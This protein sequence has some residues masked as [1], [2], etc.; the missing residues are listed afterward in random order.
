MALGDRQLRRIKGRTI[1]TICRYSVP[2]S[3]YFG[4]MAVDRVDGTVYLMHNGT[5][6]SSSG[7]YK[8]K[9]DGSLE[10]ILDQIFGTDVTK[11]YY[12]GFQ[13]IRA[14]NGKLYIIA[15]GR[16][17]HYSSAIFVMDVR[18]RSVNLLAGNR[19]NSGVDGDVTGF[20]EDARFEYIYDMTIGDDGSIYVLDNTTANR[21][22]KKISPSGFVTRLKNTIGTSAIAGYSGICVDRA[23]NVYYC[24]RS[25]QKI[26]KMDAAGNPTILAGSGTAGN[27]DG[28]GAAAT[29][30]FMSGG[31]YV[32]PYMAMDPSNQFLYVTD[33]GGIRRV[34]MDGTVTTVAPR[35]ILRHTYDGTNWPSFF[36]TTYPP[37]HGLDVDNKGDLYAVYQ[38]PL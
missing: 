11:V 5:V 6:S 33:Y 7:I 37:A 27:T 25:N 16:A 10:R 23:S 18:T 24:G 2:H 35:P 13:H 1:E 14:F 34:D 19:A 31:S 21:V 20:G 28:Q 8:V 9:P 15:H 4:G 3:Y 36:P 17:P 26:C 32:Y 29:F 38:D 22:I 12:M 30:N